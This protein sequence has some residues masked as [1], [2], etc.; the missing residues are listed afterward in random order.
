MNN[1]LL[2]ALPEAH[3]V[4]LRHFFL[5][6][7]QHWLTVTLGVSRCATLVLNTNNYPKL[8]VYFRV[9][10]LY[11]LLNTLRLTFLPETDVLTQWCYDYKN[12]RI[13]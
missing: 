5:Q 8:M 7:T 13:L 11:G 2:I 1:K 3:P 9:V 12:W 6:A 4:Y 10:A